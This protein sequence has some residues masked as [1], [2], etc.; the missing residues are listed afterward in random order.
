[1]RIFGCW[2]QPH[3][4]SA[5]KMKMK[6]ILTISSIIFGGFL[7]AQNANLKQN[8]STSELVKLQNSFPE[9]QKSEFYRQYF[10]AK[11]FEDIKREFKYKK[12]SD[13]VLKKFTDFAKIT[14]FLLILFHI[15]RMFITLQILYKL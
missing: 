11:I 10:R 4:N 1:M 13:D 5:L 8:F 6:K 3:L 9:N 14:I 15:N 2:L 12:Y 7:F